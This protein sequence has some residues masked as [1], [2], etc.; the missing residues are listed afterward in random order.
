MQIGAR[1][2]HLNGEEA[3]LVHH[4]DLLAEIEEVIAEVDAGACK[5][6]VSK[7]KRSEGVEQSVC[8]GIQAARLGASASHILGSGRRKPDAKD[9][10]K[11]SARAK[12]CD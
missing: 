6:K 3:M 1:Y 10:C 11:A 12:G 8:S 9:S 4:P 7:E 2:S 5:T